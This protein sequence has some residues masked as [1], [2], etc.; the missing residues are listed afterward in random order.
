MTRLSEF[1]NGLAITATLTALV[2][3]VLVWCLP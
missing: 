2:F 1:L 3:G